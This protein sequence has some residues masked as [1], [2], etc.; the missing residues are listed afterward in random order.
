MLWEAHLKSPP[1]SHTTF[2]A[3]LCCLNVC[4]APVCLTVCTE[5][6]HLFLS[7][8]RLAIVT[9]SAL[10]SPF[11]LPAETSILLTMSHGTHSG[12]HSMGQASPCVRGAQ[13]GQNGPV[14]VGSTSMKSLRH[15]RKP[16]PRHLGISA[17]AI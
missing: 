4:C 12:R 7:T 16:W 8:H 11:L 9:R 10:R 3:L 6:S 2:P 1:C 5:S 15:S 13:L 14:R 17:L